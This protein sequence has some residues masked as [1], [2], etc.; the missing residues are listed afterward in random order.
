V[1]TLTLSCGELRVVVLPDRGGAIVE[2]FFAGIQVMARPPK[3][4]QN[5]IPFG[6][7]DDW[8][9]AWSG[10]WQPLLPNAGT[11]YLSG[12]YPQGFH[13]SASQAVW[14]ALQVSSTEV[15]LQWD[16]EDLHCARSIN[17]SSNEIRVSGQLKNL[18]N[19]ERNF[20]MTEHIIFG[21]SLF[22]SDVELILKDQSKFMELQYDGS[23]GDHHFRTWSEVS[24][25][26]WSKVGSGTPARMGVISHID[27]DGVGIKSELIKITLTWDTNNL[28]YAWLWEEIGASQAAPWNGNF[29]AFGIEPS[30][31]P[32]GAGLGEALRTGTA[33]ILNPQEE[34]RWWVVLNFESTKAGMK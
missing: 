26:D 33:K 32:H 19:Q 2:C 22:T 28:P 21:D 25:T 10:G 17:V 6:S 18:S 14:N 23:A 27:S 3:S 1:N 15:E 20:I 12:K 11:E 24:K 7:E 34:F 5:P 9:R 30:T 31:A 8:V 16:D 13:G 4:A 29:L